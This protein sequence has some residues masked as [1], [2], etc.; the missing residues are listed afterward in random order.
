[1]EQYVFGPDVCVVF[2]SEEY[3][4]SPAVRAACDDLVT[5]PMEQ[6]LDAVNVGAACAIF[7]YEIR[8][9]RRP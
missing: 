2:G 6:G 7:L 8:R 1:L 9:Q 4:L 5:I 3:G